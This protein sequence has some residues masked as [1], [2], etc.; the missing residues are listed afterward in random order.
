[1]TA[2]SLRTPAGTATAATRSDHVVRA[3][4][5]RGTVRGGLLWGVV[6]GAFVASVTL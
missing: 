3:F 6:I 4:V 5:A 1:M 2:Q